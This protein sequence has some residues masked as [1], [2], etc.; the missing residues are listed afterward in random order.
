[1][2]VVNSQKGSFFQH[3]LM[4]FAKFKQEGCLQLY[5]KFILMMAQCAKPFA[6]FFYSP[7]LHVM[8]W[9][10]NTYMKRIDDENSSRQKDPVGT[11][12]GF[13]K[14]VAHAKP[15]VKKW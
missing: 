15:A 12:H 5:E 9:K 14:V 10:L 4:V 13:Q 7:I 1:M 11:G 6:L 2:Q 8:I 3:M